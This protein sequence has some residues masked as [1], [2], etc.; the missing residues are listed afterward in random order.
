MNVTGEF[1]KFCEHFRQDIELLE[2]PIQDSIEDGL[3]SLTAEEKERLKKFFMDVL[4]ND[5]T[6]DELVDLWDATHPEIG[7][8]GPGVKHVMSEAF[9]LL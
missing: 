3:E 8:E 1:R 5:L 2:N 7:F 4:A 6:G 9:K